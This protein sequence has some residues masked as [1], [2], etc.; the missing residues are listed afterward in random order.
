MNRYD[1][2]AARAGGQVVAH[3]VVDRE[4]GDLSPLE[5]GDRFGRRAECVALARLHLDEHQRPALTG[6]DVQFATAK[7]VAPRNNC[8]PAVLQLAAREIFAVF[9]EDLPGLRHRATQP[10]NT[11]ATA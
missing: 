8:V 3:H 6:D 10:S 9:P 5:A 4:L 1:V 2:E 7:A 11:R